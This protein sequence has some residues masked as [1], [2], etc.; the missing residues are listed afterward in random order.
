MPL[1][2]ST[3]HVSIVLDGLEEP[4]E[5]EEPPLYL[6]CGFQ[7]CPHRDKPAARVD[8]M[9]LPLSKMQAREVFAVQN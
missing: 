8:K 7:E 3:R 2:R 5:A 4:E 6:Q 9:L 1:S